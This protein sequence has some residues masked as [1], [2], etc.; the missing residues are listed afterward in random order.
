MFTACLSICLTP[1]QRIVSGQ[2]CLQDL[3]LSIK[4]LN[5][6]NHF[7]GHCSCTYSSCRLSAVV[8]RGVYQPSTSSSILRLVAINTTAI[9]AVSPYCYHMEWAES[10]EGWQR[11][12]EAWRG[13]SRFLFGICTFTAQFLV[14]FLTSAVCY[15]RIINK[16]N[17]HGITSTAVRCRDLKRRL[18]DQRRSRRRS[19]ILLSCISVFVLSWLP[20]NLL[21]LAE[22]LQPTLLDTWRFYYF[23]FFCIHLA[24]MASACVNPFLYG[25][26]NHSISTRAGRRPMVQ[27]VACLTGPS[28][29]SSYGG[30]Q[31][32]THT[33]TSHV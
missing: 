11:C 4:I 26:L 5:H 10:P 12:H 15:H 19:R 2:K 16:L 27:R 32:I 28:P 17:K 13:D 20:L 25:W 21:N 9:L 1:L 23:T 14:P 29:T 3:D 6:L 30:S 7:L 22:D 33:I 18:A 31:N 8:R 24:A